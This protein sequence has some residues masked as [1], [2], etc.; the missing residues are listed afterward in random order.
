MKKGLIMWAELAASF[1]DGNGYMISM[2]I[3][4]FFASILIFE[5]IFMLQF[6]YNIDFQKFLKSLKKMIASEDYERA[7]NFCKSVSKTSLPKITLKAIEASE[8]DPTTVRGTIEE[9]TIEFL[10]KIEN[11]VNTL[12][13]LATIIMLLGIL[14]TIDS[15]WWAFHSVDVLDT[16]KKQASLANGIAASLNPTATGI[17]V[18]MLILGSHQF[19]KGLAIRI[20]ERVHLG[21]A[22]LHNLLVPQDVATTVV[23][24]A[25][26]PMMGMSESDV[27]TD[28]INE[29][30]PVEEGPS[31][32]DFDDASVEDIKDEEEI[33]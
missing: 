25:P 30:P 20:T 18:C 11:R 16:A 22:I 26:T 14:G 13:A 27:I 21:L 29:A 33:I 2:L 23:A 32:D 9:E 4:A 24:A 8:N 1:Q 10:P 12:P 17:L 28:N 31:D 6:V 5:R 3:L 7:I 15:L 19:I